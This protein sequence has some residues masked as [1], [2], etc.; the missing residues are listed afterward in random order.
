MILQISWDRLRIVENGSARM[1]LPL[2]RRATTLVFVGVAVALAIVFASFVWPGFFLTKSC[3]SAGVPTESWYGHSYCYETVQVTSPTL[4]CPFS[5]GDDNWSGPSMNVSFWDV[6]FSLAPW[7]CGVSHGVAVAVTE[8]GSM[9]QYGTTSY[10]PDGGFVGGT[11][12][13]SD[14]KSGI[15]QSDLFSNNV[16]LLVEVGA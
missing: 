6:S 5:G 7:V 2:T 14:L 11:W 1:T 12:L 9:I 16:T 13:A 10:S 4:S 8:P 15:S 3:P